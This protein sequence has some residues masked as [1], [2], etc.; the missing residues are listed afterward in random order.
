MST[1]VLNNAGAAVAVKFFG[2]QARG[3][4]LEVFLPKNLM[5]DCGKMPVHED[6]S[7]NH[8]R[9]LSSYIAAVSERGGTII[10]REPGVHGPLSQVDRIN[11]NRP[12]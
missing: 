8:I 9:S 1:Q 12:R 5:K 10:Y 6:N 3:L 2:G 4:C 7:P 11:G